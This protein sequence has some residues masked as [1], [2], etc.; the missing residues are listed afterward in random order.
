MGESPKG[1]TKAGP[2][3]RRWCALGCVV[4][5]T[6]LVTLQ[7]RGQHCEPRTEPERGP[8]RAT[9]RWDVARFES[10]SSG[11]YYESVS[12]GLAFRQ[13]PF[14]ARARLPYYRLLHGGTTENGFGDL[15]VKL[16]T[17]L[18]EGEVWS[19]GGALAASF[20]TGSAEKRLGMGHVMVGPSVWVER[21]VEDLFVGGELGY[22]RGIGADSDET[23]AHEQAAHHHHA[24]KPHL[25]SI[26]N[27]MNREELWLSL[28]TSYVALP[29]LQLNLGALVAGPLSEDGSTRVSTTGGVEFPLG[30]LGTAVGIE[31]DLLGLTRRTLGFVAV[32]LGP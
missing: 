27:P 29:E 6:S 21:R 3:P 11:G 7:A 26:P 25:G 13:G 5:A 2:P 22:S 15:D 18:H 19:V 8:F 14:R 32:S 23:A 17:A 28:S 9:V 1:V 31:V 4:I 16:E 12:L 30:K 20:P 10:E 24:A